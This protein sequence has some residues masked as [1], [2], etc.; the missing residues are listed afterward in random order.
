MAEP[1]VVN[2]G[3]LVSFARIGCLDVIGR[4]PCLTRCQ[5]LVESDLTHLGARKVDLQAVWCCS[6]AE[7]PSCPSPGEIHQRSS[8]RR[9]LRGSA[10]ILGQLAPRS[11]AVGEAGAGRFA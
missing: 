11:W 8:E 7:A 6:E 4:L 2:T 9:R 5:G 1:I 10:T 3:P